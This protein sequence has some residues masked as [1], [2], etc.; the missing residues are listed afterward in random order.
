MAAEYVHLHVHSQYSMLDGAI[1]LGGLVDRV[2]SMGMDAVALTDHGNMFGAIQF[3]AACNAAGVRPI[4]GCEIYLVTGERT[5][6]SIRQA[7]H[8]VLLAASQTGYGNLVRIVSRAWVDGLVRG[9][10]RV[11]FEL[12]RANRE[13]VVGLSAC[14]GGYLAQEILQKGPEAGRSAMA[15][16][17]DS[18]DAGHFFVELQDHGF[19]EQQP[20]NEILVDLARDLSVPI[21]ASNDCH[22]MDRSDA[23]AQL[24]L[25]CIGAGRTLEEMGRQHHK[26]EEIYLKSPEEMGRFRRLIQDAVERHGGNWA[27]AARALP[28]DRANLHHLAKRLGMK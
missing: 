3:H 6:P 9:I 26:S 23:H 18:F 11:D 12:L 7:H 1:R 15:H 24:A 27:A 25:Q 21:V 13:G 17:R 20:L 22:Y 19:P 4:L 8:L 28:D 14:M 10:P 16:L 2:S 5:D